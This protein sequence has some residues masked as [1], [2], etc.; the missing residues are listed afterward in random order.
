MMIR[1]N[2]QLLAWPLLLGAIPAE[3]AVIIADDFPTVEEIADPT[4]RYTFRMLINDDCI[5]RAGDFFT[6]Y[7]IF[8]PTDPIPPAHPPTQPPNWILSTPGT[9][10]TPSGLPPFT[11]N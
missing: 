6:F 4:F 9:G 1:R 10:S 8:L 11:D 5:V 2:S 7:D 3:S